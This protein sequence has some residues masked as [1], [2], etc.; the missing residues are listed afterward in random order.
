MLIN[1]LIQY[2]KLFFSTSG[3]SIKFEKEADTGKELSIVLV[4]SLE[5]RAKYRLALFAGIISRTKKKFILFGLRLL[6]FLTS[7]SNFAYHLSL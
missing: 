1:L 4:D 2:N 3:D 5:R 7:L 6:F